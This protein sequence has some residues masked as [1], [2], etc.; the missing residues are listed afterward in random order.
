[1]NKRRIIPPLS[2]K[3]E[4][5][6]WQKVTKGNP[7]VCWEWNSNRSYNG[8]GRFRMPAGWYGAHRIAY[9]LTKGLI[10]K[11]A[12]VL[13][14]CDNPGCV[15]PGHLWLGNQTDNMADMFKKG[16]GRRAMGKD[17][18][19]Y[20]H[21]EKMPR[22]EDHGSSKLKPRQ[23]QEIRRLYATG[24][25]KQRDLAVQYSVTQSLVSNILHRNLWAHI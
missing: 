21:P 20:T 7:D 22:G 14:T 13:H 8:Y 4:G 18:G 23:V 5:R 9:T 11:D 24:S 2:A 25:Y 15:N 19:A 10:A 16:R 1:M 12:L 6:F 17:N 3:D